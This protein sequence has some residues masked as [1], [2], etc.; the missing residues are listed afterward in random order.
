VEIVIC[1]VPEQGMKI[2][3]HRIISGLSAGITALL[4]IICL[5]MWFSYDPT[6]NVVINMPGMDNQ[7]TTMSA[8]TGGEDVKIGE[9][10]ETFDGVSAD[11]PG[12][13]TQFRGENSDNISKKTVR[14]A[15]NWGDKGPEILWSIDLGEGHAAPAVMN[16]RVYVLDYDEEK[17]GDALRCFS[18]ADGKEIWWRWYKVHIKRNHGMS[19]TVPAV[20][21]KYVVTIGPRCHVMCTDAQTGDFL[22]GLDLE[23]DFGT[24]TPFWYT[25]QC[26]LIDNSIAVIA[27]AG[28][29]LLMGVDCATG[30]VVWETPNP[31]GWTMSHTS[32]MPMTLAG[33]KMYVYSAIEG[34]VGV[35]AEGQD[36]GT[37]L[38]ETTLW[39]HSV[40][41][42]SPVILE[43][44][45][46]FLT[47]GYGVGSS[48]LQ[49][50]EE[51]GIFSVKK[52]Q[53]Y[54]PKEGLASEQQTP[55]LY[56]GHLL[57]IL[58]K[59][60]G[61][62]RNQFVCYHPDNCKRLVW[63][64]GKTNRFGL[65]PYLIADGKIFVLDD[66]GVLTLLEASITGYK[67]LAQAK[68][69]D[70]HD[71]WGPLALAGSR[72]L[73]RDSKRMVCL[74]VGQK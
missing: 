43:D 21:E 47:A 17:K 27:P 58:P 61:G 65:G 33:R 14:V 45:R 53:E 55:I 1:T 22:W 63:S 25:G 59:D 24:K 30:Q 20:T 62:L 66:N 48:M 74:E 36:R 5:A 49:V 44:G 29:V 68:I 41:A 57:G 54:P 16:G 11:L 19:R 60:A 2:M 67:Q 64:S 39:S 46:I 52:L 32:I 70:G 6:V 34:M 4:G 7:P 51:K 8:L 37:V 31:H 56:K 23:K 71:A 50:T 26:P 69:L 72:L 9:H 73:L 13:W 28:K 42:P 38:W 10:F 3:D 12:T 15:S 35:S 18:L 40:L